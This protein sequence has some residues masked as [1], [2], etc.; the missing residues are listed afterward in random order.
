M[1]WITVDG[2]LKSGRRTMASFIPAAKLPAAAGA[3]DAT[4]ETCYENAT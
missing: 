1:F 3:E 2:G 4:S